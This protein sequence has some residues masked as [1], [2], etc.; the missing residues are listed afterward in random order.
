V[1]ERD[2][3]D[4][5]L[6]AL[7][8][9][10]DAKKQRLDALVDDYASGL[11]TR[12]QLV[13]AKDTAEGSLTAAEHKLEALTRSRAGAKMTPVGRSVRDARDKGDLAWRRQLVALL[14][15]RVVIQPSPS[16]AHMRNDER[17]NGWRFKPED[18]EI[19]WLA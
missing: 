18:V 4:R 6:T 7:V 11:L 16:A 10:R 17:W 19:R 8:K 9:D 14:I 1:T 12:S 15:E 5:V 13:S 2:S 3:G